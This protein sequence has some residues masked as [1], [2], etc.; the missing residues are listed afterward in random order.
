MTDTEKKY[1]AA[2][3][4]VFARYGV[5]KA[6]MTEIAEDAGVSKPT[7][8]TVFRNKDDALAGAIRFAKGNALEAM[9][10]DWKHLDTLPAK[11]DVFFQ[12]IVVA[13]Y[14]LLHA[15]PDADALDD[16]MGPASAAAVEETRRWSSE[17]LEEVFSPS[18]EAIV[19]AGLTIGEIAE[20][21]VSTSMNA[22]RLAANRD[23]LLRNLAVL[24]TSV[25]AVAQN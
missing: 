1:A 11:L 19:A 20:F 12:R 15:A 21:T 8:Y 5:R 18:E 4:S 22:K 3:L 7:L 24:R 14:D 6:T 17:A 2:A 16:G 10:T 25:L 23:E 9:R 13:G